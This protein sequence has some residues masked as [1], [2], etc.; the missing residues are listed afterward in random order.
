V[1]PL[2]GTDGLTDV[3]Q[4]I[5]SRVREFVAL[6]AFELAIGYAQQRHTFGM[7]I[8]QHQAILFK[9]ADMGTKTAAAHQ[10]MVLAARH[11][12][13]GQ[14][15]DLEAGMAKYL[16]SEPCKEVVE[17]ALRIHGGSGYS[18]DAEIERLYRDAPGAS[19]ASGAS[20]AP[21]AP[22]APGGALRAGHVTHGCTDGLALAGPNVHRR[23]LARPRRP[24][25]RTAP[26]T[27]QRLLWA[28]STRV[29]NLA[30]SQRL[31]ASQSA[32]RPRCCVCTSHA[33]GR[34]TARASRPASAR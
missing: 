25:R 9:L 18:T 13:A 17:D 19:A 33:A 32:T 12:D 27:S 5:I 4:D 7:P 8:A 1:A 16:A 15:S 23:A 31:Y 6:R 22:G 10:M 34:N 24:Q 29:T 20:A 3:Q 26:V 14:Q 21:G 30:S 11:K 28:R 2:T